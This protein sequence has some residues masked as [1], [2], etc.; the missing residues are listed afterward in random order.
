MTHPDDTPTIDDV[1]TSTEVT[2]PDHREHG[3]MPKHVDGDE[4]EERLEQEREEVGLDPE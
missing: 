3:K 4:L 1:M 2:H